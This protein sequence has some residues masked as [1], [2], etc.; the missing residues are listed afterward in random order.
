MDAANWAKGLQQGVRTLGFALFPPACAA[1]GES[2]PNDATLCGACQVS[3]ILADHPCFETA[4]HEPAHATAT[5]ALATTVTTLAPYAYGGSVKD[6]LCRAKFS[7]D[8]SAARA[9]VAL[10][11]NDEVKSLVMSAF[12]EKQLD[13]VT[14]I[15]TPFRRRVRRGFCL[16]SFI[17]D[18][19]SK[20]LEL[21]VEDVLVATRTDAPLSEA[22]NAEERLQK[23]S[24]RYQVRGAT[25][26]KSILLVDDIL[27]TGAT[28]GEARRVLEAAGREVH[29]FAL[30]QAEREYGKSHDENAHESS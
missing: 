5:D 18:A 14:F 8:E 17:A 4:P 9:C 15:P 3:C 25:K 11:Q 28:L 22:E 24:G 13:A 20:I 21:P 7:N 1:C 12:G 10:L 27:T 16:P 6:L 26:A 30:A 19:L 29:C 23:V 2:V